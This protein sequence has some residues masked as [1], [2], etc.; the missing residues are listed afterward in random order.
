MS[1]K[2]I[3][4]IGGT[5]AQ[6]AAVATALLTAKFTIRVLTRDPENPR[7]K[8]LFPPEYGVE[9]FK[10]T[11]TSAEKKSIFSNWVELF[12]IG[13]FMDIEAVRLALQD[14]YGVFVNTDS[15]L[16]ERF[17]NEMR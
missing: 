15:M 4:I 14:C 1:S 11:E 7:A 16:A 17:I 9:M 12:G 8:S 6:G 13:S 3:L 2:R 5:G 10:G